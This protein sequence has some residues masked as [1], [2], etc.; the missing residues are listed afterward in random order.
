MPR[1]VLSFV[2]FVT[3]SSL[4]FAQSPNDFTARL[5]WVPI[6]LAEQHLVG[7]EGQATAD[8]SRGRLSIRGSF[9]GLPAP[10]TA[11]RLHRG[12]ATGAG[13]PPIADLEVTPS[14]EGTF[15]GEIELDR[16]QR[17]ALAA[18]LLYIQLYAEPGVPPDNA[19][20]RGW[21]LENDGSRLASGR[22]N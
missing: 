18:G 1:Q 4:A 2:A 16:E 6:S 12:A 3:V 7:G 10:A 13:G 5:A 9:S 20:L 14:S 15:N 22:R 19:V 17:A 8:L 11:A 21:L